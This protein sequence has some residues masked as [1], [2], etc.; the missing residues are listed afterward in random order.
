MLFPGYYCLP[1]VI[2]AAF[3]LIQMGLLG[4][5]DINLG[6]GASEADTPP[7][8]GDSCFWALPPL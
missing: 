1:L 3:P 6:P 7:V 8:Q 4:S 5:L 2:P